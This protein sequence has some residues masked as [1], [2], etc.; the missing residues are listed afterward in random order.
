MFDEQL[1]PVFGDR[2][3]QAHEARVRG[4]VS[5]RALAGVIGIITADDCA[6]VSADEPLGPD[7]D[8]PG[9]GQGQLWLTG[10]RKPAGQ[11]RINGGLDQ[12]HGAAAVRV[13]VRP[14]VVFL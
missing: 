5:G 6:A 3:L 2:W 9:R 1:V 13:A 7:M 4:E 8:N 10:Q 12:N 14:V 11:E